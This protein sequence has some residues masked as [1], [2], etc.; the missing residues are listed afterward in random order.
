M[1]MTS[2][3]ETCSQYRTLGRA[4]SDPDASDD[5]IAPDM[6]D[7]LMPE[8]SVI[9]HHFPFLL[10]V[11]RFF[12]QSVFGCPGIINFVSRRTAWFDAVLESAISEK[13]IEQVVIVA[14]GFSTY[15]YRTSHP[16]IRFFEIDLPSAISRKKAL[17]N[18]LGLDTAQVCFVPA[19]LSMVTLESAL[20]E[21]GW[22][23]PKLRSLF[24]VEG[25]LYYLPPIAV[26]ILL[27]SISQ[28]SSKGSLLAFDVIDDEVFSNR[29]FSRGYQALRLIVANRGEELKSG[30]GISKDQISRK[31][32][33]SAYHSSVVYEPVKLLNG[34]EMAQE[35]QQTGGPRR[36]A[37]PPT[38]PSFFHYCLAEARGKSSWLN[39]PSIT[40]KIYVT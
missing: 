23:D 11:Y 15:S 29:S 9:Y 21:T 7:I 5:C 34:K 17:I 32:S 39:D 4:I 3:P 19:D 26:N 30:M 25:L 27:E 24:L 18:Q 13:G 20:Q 33:Q 14:S 8:R 12:V 1:N 16:G 38:L 35:T 2:M 6:R 28:S 36:K 10:I 37:K 31:L 40:T 22:F